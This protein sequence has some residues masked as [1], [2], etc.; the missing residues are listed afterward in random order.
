MSLASYMHRDQG[1]R[2]NEIRFPFSIETRS[3]QCK[4]L[5]VNGEEVLGGENGGALGIN[6]LDDVETLNNL[7]NIGNTESNIRVKS[8]L[9][10]EGDTQ[11][12]SLSIDRK[13]G[14]ITSTQLSNIENSINTL[15]QQLNK[16]MSALN[17]DNINR[18]IQTSYDISVNGAFIQ[19]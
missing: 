8:D 4:E 6:S 11:N 7:K 18:T 2:F 9:M 5:Y 12:P 16:I 19:G 15:Q 1:G 13:T 17:I 10:I 3:V 14:N